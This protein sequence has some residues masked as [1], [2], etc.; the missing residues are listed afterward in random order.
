[1]AK[2]TGPHICEQCGSEF[3]GWTGGNN[4]NRFCSRVCSVESRKTGRTLI[5]CKC[6]ICKENYKARPDQVKIGRSK[7]C[8]KK[9]SYIAKRRKER[10]K[11]VCKQCG[12]EFSTDKWSL[13]NGRGVY[14]SVKCQRNSTRIK[15]TALTDDE[16]SRLSKKFFNRQKTKKTKDYYISWLLGSSVKDIPEQ[17]IELKRLTIKRKRLIKE[18]THGNSQ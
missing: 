13:S 15:Q 17:L 18:V 16:W 8:S 2:R 9:C 5:D 6:T 14:C 12:V 10:I 7:Y 4:V 11:A 3:V 1:M